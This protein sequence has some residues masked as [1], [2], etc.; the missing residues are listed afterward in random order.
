MRAGRKAAVKMKRRSFLKALIA[1]PLAIR[2]GTFALE[3]MSAQ[4]RYNG[5]MPRCNYS[6]LMSVTL[7]NYVKNGA[8]EDAIFAPSQVFRMLA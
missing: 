7:D 4:P 1:V 6:E 5:N 3:S 2:A 8:I